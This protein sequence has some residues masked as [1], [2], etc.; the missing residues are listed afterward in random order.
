MKELRQSIAVRKGF[1]K[2]LDSFIAEFDNG[3]DGII[4]RADPKVASQFPHWDRIL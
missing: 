3:S 2:V 4:R 1:K